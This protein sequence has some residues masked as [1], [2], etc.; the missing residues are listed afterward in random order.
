MKILIAIIVFSIIIIIHELG[1]FILAKLNGVYVTEFSVGMG[2]RLLTT[3]KGETRYSLKL[4]PFGGSCMMLGEDEDV[5]DD[6]RAFGKKSV[7]ARISI[8]AAGPIFNFIL[9]FILAIFVIGMI[10]YDPAKVIQVVDNSPTSMAGIQE[11]DIIKKFDGRTIDFGRD[12]SFIFQVY[13]ITEKPIEVVYE[14][15]GKDYKTTITPV[16][17]E[18]YRLGF[19]YTP[20]ETEAEIEGLSENSPLANAGL[21]IGDVITSFNGVTI[22]SSSD[23]YNYIN[24]HP[25]TKAPID[26]V[27]KRANEEKTVTVTP[28]LAGTSYYIGLG[29]NLRKQK[30]NPLEVIEYSFK[31]V[32]FNITTTIENVAKLI[33]G[34]VSTDQIAGPVGVVDVIGST[35]DY[36]K[37][38]GL[39]MI[40]VNI[41][42]L[43]IMISANLGVM[44]LLPFPALD[45]GRLIFMIIEILRGGKPVPKEKEGMVHMIG[46]ILLMALM[47]FV[48]YNDISRLFH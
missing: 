38:Y 45:G 13:P 23:L 41:S 46:F 5:K 35:Y 37:E 39:K 8:I 31:E 27:F 29:I 42:S 33:R 9:A 3:V 20:D 24:D 7:W 21:E 11:G 43:V 15:D 17:K 4:F 28:E 22:G 6:D 1:H 26:I 34:K 12:V 19:T 36:S 16:L 18:T 14:R 2:P 32:K 48:L 40:F 44:N 25:I 30:A 10:G 47:V